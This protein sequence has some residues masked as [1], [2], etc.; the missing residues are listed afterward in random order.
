MQPQFAEHRPVHRIHEDLVVMVPGD[1]DDLATVF[2][3]CQQCLN[4]QALRPRIGRRGLEE[5]PLDDAA[6]HGDVLIV[7]VPALKDLTNMPVASMKNLHPLS[8]VRPSR[9]GHA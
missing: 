8:P 2:P 1:N 9:G 6:K 5:V 7:P 4:D 3:Q